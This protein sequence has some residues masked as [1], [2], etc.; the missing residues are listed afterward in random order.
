[1]RIGNVDIHGSSSHQVTDCVHHHSE[2]KKE[3]G[4]MKMSAS[5]PVSVQNIVQETKETTTLWSPVDWLKSLL[6]RGRSL[7]LRLWSNDIPGVAEG[8]ANQKAEGLEATKQSGADTALQH[9][10]TEEHRTQAEQMPPYFIM[11]EKKE[12]SHGMM[13]RI[14]LKVQNV[15]GHLTKH[16]PFAQTGSFQTKQQNKE[17][18]RRRSRYRKED[19]E[20]DCIL[21][22]DSF[23]LDSYNGKGEYSKLSTDNKKV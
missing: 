5:A 10:K 22:D 3:T 20:I 7:G 6:K 18:L 12:Q 11:P 17:D 9:P 13:Q 1:M 21:T 16:L 8:K 15:S 4:G 14:L 19:T 2:Q 23:L